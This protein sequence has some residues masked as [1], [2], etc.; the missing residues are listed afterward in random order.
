MLSGNLA[1]ER[2]DAERYK[3]DADRIRGYP[4]PPFACGHMAGP[5]DLSVQA[6]LDTEFDVPFC[7]ADPDSARRPCPLRLRP[8]R[9]HPCTDLAEPQGRGP[10]SIRSCR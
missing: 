3:A 7:G 6:S 9:C 4:P 5:P 8:L 1:G 2:A 10:L